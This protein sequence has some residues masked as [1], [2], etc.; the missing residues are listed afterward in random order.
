MSSTR[1]SDNPPGFSTGTEAP[2]S[3]LPSIPPDRTYAHFPR[4]FW[5]TYDSTDDRFGSDMHVGGD[6]LSRQPRDC[7]PEK[8]ECSCGAHVLHCFALDPEGPVGSRWTLFDAEP[9]EGGRWFQNL[10]G[11]MTFEPR[12]GSYRLH[13]CG[14]EAAGLAES[15]APVPEPQLSIACR[16]GRHWAPER[17]SG[18]CHGKRLD[19]DYE[20]K[21][22]EC[23]V[24]HGQEVKP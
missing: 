4:S 22:C 12:Y 15:L 23:P 18:S 16:E 24:C 19:D 21:P 17:P 5:D 20:W 6:L 2:V 11:S 9:T 10:D 14:T 7:T 8:R 13:W 3:D 1:Y